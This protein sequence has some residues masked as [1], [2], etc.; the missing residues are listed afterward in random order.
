MAS[1]CTCK[2]CPNRHGQINFDFRQR[3]IASYRD[4]TPSHF[5]SDAIQFVKGIRLAPGR[6]FGYLLRTTIYI[7][8]EQYD[9]AIADCNKIIRLNPGFARA[10]LF[11]GLAYLEK[12]QHDRAAADFEEAYR[13][14]PDEFRAEYKRLGKLGS[15]L[16]F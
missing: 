8:T 12:N 2:F 13:L 1:K 14:K 15:R 16:S 4:P 5:C 9:L 10:Y 6:L 11:R 7:E 3:S